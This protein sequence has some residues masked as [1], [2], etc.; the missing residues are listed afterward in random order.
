MKTDLT[1][2]LKDGRALG[3]AEYG[4]HEGYPIFYFHGGQ[5]SRLSSLFMHS[6]A[7]QM[8]VRIIAPDRPGIGLSTFQK[9]RTI[10]G[11]GRDVEELAQALR[12]SDYSLFGISGGAPHVLSCLAHDPYRARKVSIVAG[13]APYHYAGSLS[14]MWVPV[15][16]L[17]WLAAMKSDKQLKKFI[18]MD[19]NTL[20]LNPDKRVAQFQKYL[21]PA[22]RSLLRKYPNYGWEFIRGS[23]EAYKQGIDGVAQEWQLYVKDWGIDIDSITNAVT[24]WYG[25]EDKMSPVQRGIYYQTHL[26]NSTLHVVDGE[27]HFSLI[28]NKLSVI[29]SDLKV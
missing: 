6:T 10:K 5:E 1:I 13:A 25:S 27:A 2:T 17:H 3:Y 26:K 9:G 4:D 15:R 28:R 24:L 12:L 16:I 22:D 19:Y 21:P 20:V 14:G 18:R 29:L 23:I 8:K 7:V 11:W